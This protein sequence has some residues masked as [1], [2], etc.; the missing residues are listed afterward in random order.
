MNFAII[1]SMKRNILY[2]TT[3]LF[4]VGCSR[5]P[6]VVVYDA[7]TQKPLDIQKSAQESIQKSVQKVKLPEIGRAHV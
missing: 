4:L 6:T 7:P 2:I 5:E 1:A 3:I